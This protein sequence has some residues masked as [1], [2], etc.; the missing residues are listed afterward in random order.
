M[1]RDETC[2]ICGRLGQ[3]RRYRDGDRAYIHKTQRCP[4]GMLVL[5]CCYVPPGAAVASSM[6]CQDSSPPVN[7]PAGQT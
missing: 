5:D 3:V 6:S 1:T 2:P 4:V 7:R